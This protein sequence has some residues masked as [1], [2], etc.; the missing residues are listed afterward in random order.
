MRLFVKLV[1]KNME[2]G[3]KN[4]QELCSIDVVSKSLYGVVIEWRLLFNKDR[5]KHQNHKI[6]ANEFKANEAIEQIKRSSVNYRN[7]YEYR[8]NLLYSC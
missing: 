6:Y 1:R 2:T 4:S 3:S 7:N 8:L 5:V